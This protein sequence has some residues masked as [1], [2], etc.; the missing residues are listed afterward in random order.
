MEL[1]LDEI[2]I[3][4]KREKVGM[5]LDQVDKVIKEMDIIPN[6]TYKEIIDKIDADERLELYQGQICSLKGTN[7]VELM[8][9]K[10]KK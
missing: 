10:L 8:T 7:P 1:C 9:K 3:N 5:I 2:Y 4:I 6:F